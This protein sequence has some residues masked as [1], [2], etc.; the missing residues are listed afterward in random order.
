[1]KNIKEKLCRLLPH[2]TPT[3]PHPI[4][5]IRYPVEF[6]SEER[7][8]FDY[9]K[10]NTLSMTSDER[11]FNTMLACK[12]VLDQ[13]IEG[14]FIECGVWRG[15][16]SILAAGIFKLY[17]SDRKIYLFD[18]FTGMTEPGKKDIRISDGSLQAAI[19]EFASKKCLS[20]LDDVKE[21]FRRYN[22][23]FDNVIFVQGD[24]LQTLEC[25]SVPSKIAVLRLDT[26]WYESTRKELEILYPRLS[27]NGVLIIDDYGHWGGSKKAVDE[28]FATYGNRLFFNYVD[29]TGRSAVKGIYHER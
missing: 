1:M 19:N 22:L 13:N 3:P 12:Y 11:L 8:L 26:D 6:S 14:D 16:N 18:T 24:V 20:S 4:P 21:N 25:K 10:K 7:E 15:G 2:P 17:K 27:S 28:Y 9:V 23:L 5:A 29:Y